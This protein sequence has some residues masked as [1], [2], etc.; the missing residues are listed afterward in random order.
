M[1]GWLKFEGEGGDNPVNPPLLCIQ[2]CIKYL[3][4]VRF[5][6]RGN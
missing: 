4:L 3:I 5:L 1:G 6:A 2:S